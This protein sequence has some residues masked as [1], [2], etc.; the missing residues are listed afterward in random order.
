MSFVTFAIVDFLFFL[1]VL[2]FSWFIFV[3]YYMIENR[4]Y[5]QSE[6]LKFSL[7][8]RYFKCAHWFSDS[9]KILGVDIRQMCY[10]CRTPVKP[11]KWKFQNHKVFHAALTR[12][13]EQKNSLSEKNFWLFRICLVICGVCMYYI[14]NTHFI[15]IFTEYK[16]FGLLRKMIL[17]DKHFILCIWN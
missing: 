10:T 4:I 12:Q 14:L 2:L 13:I 16:Q 17:L 3:L 7:L 6:F 5:L 9:D 1:F 11:S 15:N 8:C